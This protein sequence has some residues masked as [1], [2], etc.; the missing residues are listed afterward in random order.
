MELHCCPRLALSW[1]CLCT[2]AGLAW[3]PIVVKMKLP[4]TLG[5]VLDLRLG[6]RPTPP[7]PKQKHQPQET[8][9]GT[10]ARQR[11]R[12]QQKA[13][14]QQQQQEGQLQEPSP[15]DVQGQPAAASSA[16][17]SSLIATSS[18]AAA[19][20]GTSKSASRSAD[21]AAGAS[22]PPAIASS[23]SPAA[24][25]GSSS[26]AALAERDAV[27][28]R[29]GEGRSS[30]GSSSS[31]GRG[32]HGVRGEGIGGGR[33]LGGMRGPAMEN[34]AEFDKLTEYADLLLGYGELGIYTKTKEQLT[35][36]LSGSG[37]SEQQQQQQQQ[38]R[39]VQQRQ[40]TE[41]GGDGSRLVEALLSAATPAEQQIEGAG[42]SVCMSVSAC[43]CARAK[44]TLA[45]SLA[46]PGGGATTSAVPEGV[47]PPEEDDRDM[48]GESFEVKDSKVMPVCAGP[49]AHGARQC[50]MHEIIKDCTTV[51]RMDVSA[52]STAVTA[53]KTAMG[54]KDVAAM[55]CQKSGSSGVLF[56]PMHKGLSMRG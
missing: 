39:Q 56:H 13:Q 2:S 19:A 24:A 33:G 12:K 34:S 28:N 3:L 35:K 26:G 43:M 50:T 10:A 47:S 25:E 55:L 14:Q 29:S 49:L 5:L 23:S 18:A 41:E 32:Q 30:S 36:E 1:T 48:F 17:P 42:E 54:C 52:Q 37:S 22:A 40:D 20:G 4:L 46:S 21:Q 38:Q 53:C 15:T 31:A 7:P 45:G 8:L 27:R 6:A 51:R 16:P 11:Q 9:G 44:V